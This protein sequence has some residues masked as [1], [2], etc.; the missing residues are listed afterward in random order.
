[1]G[2]NMV[3]SRL[4]PL[5]GGRCAAV[6]VNCA[7]V[8]GCGYQPSL[9]ECNISCGANQQCPD[10][11][12]CSNGICKS[13][14]YA[15]ICEGASNDAAPKSDAARLDG[16]PS[17]TCGNQRMDGDEE[18]DDGNQRNGD[19]CESN[20]T[21]VPINCGLVPN[22]GC[23]AGLVC[24]VVSNKRHC[25]PV[26]T[27]THQ[28]TCTS[29]YQCLGGSTCVHVTDN[30]AACLAY[31]RDDN[32]CAGFGAGSRCLST[33]ETGERICTFQCTAYAPRGRNGCPD[34]MECI[35]TEDGNKDY[36]ECFETGNVPVGGRC[37]NLDDCAEQAICVDLPSGPTCVQQC[38][39]A[40][41]GSCPGGQTCASQSPPVLIGNDQVGLCRGP[42]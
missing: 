7:L 15:T 12:T 28:Q 32:D 2:C 14:S 36:T 39:V 20:C 37:A 34:N 35:A 19:G 23:G 22:T 26:G 3:T 30:A 24:D 41:R 11:T 16:A 13:P 18:C 38:S 5:H 21:V 1:M 31:C 6:L 40:N 8:V 4:R 42:N 10:G 25:R 29:N 17:G 9:N 27:G 33:L